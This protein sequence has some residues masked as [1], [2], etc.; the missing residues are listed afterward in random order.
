VIVHRGLVSGSDDNPTNINLED[1]YLVENVGNENGKGYQLATSLTNDNIYYR[2]TYVPNTMDP[3]TRTFSNWNVINKYQKITTD[4]TEALEKSMLYRHKDG[5]LYKSIPNPNN[6]AENII[7]RETVN[8]EE[9][10]FTNDNV[11]SRDGINLTSN[12]NGSHYISGEDFPMNDI[13]F[14]V[15]HKETV[16]S[17]HKNIF[18][19]DTNKENMIYL[20]LDDGL[21]YGIGICSYNSMGSGDTNNVVNHNTPVEVYSN[22]N[23]FNATSIYSKGGRVIELNSDTLIKT[24]V[25]PLD[26]SLLTEQSPIINY[27]RYFG[28]CSSFAYL[29]NGVLRTKSLGDITYNL[30]ST[31]IGALGNICDFGD[32]HNTISPWMEEVHNDIDSFRI[33]TPIST[34]LLGSV[35]SGWLGDTNINPS[36]NLAK[37]IKNSLGNQSY[38]NLNPV[39]YGGGLIYDINGESLY[40]FEDTMSKESVLRQSD[41]VTS[42]YDVS[43]LTA[44]NSVITRYPNVKTLKDVDLILSKSDDNTL[45]LGTTSI[46]VGSTA[47]SYNNE[48]HCRNLDSNLGTYSIVKKETGRVLIK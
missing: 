18:P 7:V 40:S 47:K 8:V 13:S 20:N 39:G 21:S 19:L 46:S 44:I 27:D 6:P 31:S 25:N 42:N 32:V 23:L 12:S 30:V 15:T 3:T 5:H 29:L 2:V 26:S 48:I 11:I 34:Y 4:K 22:Y 10:I 28:G 36:D 35:W 43:L 41:A 1:I 37:V 9:P 38:I 33:D 24:G 16:R 45:I 17:N 14:K